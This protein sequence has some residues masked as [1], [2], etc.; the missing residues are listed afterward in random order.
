MN[1]CILSYAPH[2][3]VVWV[4]V[5]SLFTLPVTRPS[6]VLLTLS[7]HQAIGY[8]AL[9]NTPTRQSSAYHHLCDLTSCHTILANLTKKCT[10]Q[11]ALTL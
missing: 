7:R 3:L 2:D 11:P 8:A 9:D 4:W 1:I 10:V 5:E 6:Q